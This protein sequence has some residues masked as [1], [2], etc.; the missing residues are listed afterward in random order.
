MTIGEILTYALTV[1]LPEG[2]TPSLTLVDDLPPGL[3]YVAGSTTV[4]TTG[5]N[6]T[7]P[8]PTVTN[9]G[10]SGDDVTFSFGA[11]SV[12]GRQQHGQQ[13]LRRPLAGARAGHRRQRGREPARPDQPDQ[14]RH[15]AHRRRGDRALEHGCGD[16][17]RAAH[18]HHQVGHA[19]TNVQAGTVLTYTV[20]FS[21]TGTSMAYDVNA[22]DTLAPGTAF[23]G[24]AGL[25]GPR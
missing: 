3:A 12:D 5:F 20:R 24:A 7:V 4:D 22:T 25:R 6:G 9:T 11:I 17:G 13:Q 18:R 1:T 19:F 16:G 2:T 23:S 14:Q 8:V 10:G 15:A 21:N